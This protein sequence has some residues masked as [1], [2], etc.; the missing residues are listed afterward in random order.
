MLYRENDDVFAKTFIAA[1][2]SLLSIQFVVNIG[3]NMGI[4][5][6][7]GVTLPFVS[8]GGSS[9]ISSAIFL[10][11]AAAMGKAF[12]SKNVLEIT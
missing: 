2:F 4:I 3:M 11:I 9:L 8:Y 10:G 12:K 5:P 6:I 1:T 7:V